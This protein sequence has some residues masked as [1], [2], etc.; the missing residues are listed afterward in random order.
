MKKQNR[1]QKT[2]KQE[3]VELM[4]YVELLE[5]KNKTL[6]EQLSHETMQ[7]QQLE[8]MYE[9]LL[10]EKN[11][12]IL[13]LKGKI[14]S[15]D[16]TLNS[17]KDKNGH[18][19]IVKGEEDDIYPGEQRDFILSLIETAQQSDEQYARRNHICQSLLK[20]NKKNG[21]REYMQDKIYLALK[22]FKFMDERTI[23]LL[24][25]SNIRL[26]SGRTHHKMTLNGDPRYR[27]SISKTPSDCR[28]GLNA[29]SEINRHFF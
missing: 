23:R 26:I 2:T 8:Q 27:V 24:E 6:V 19:L 9:E 3:K 20:A 12:E 22:D 7:Y 28:T 11:K 17:Y 10:E 14:I 5:E 21:T 15:Q 25:E 4:E 16:I 18:P 1:K 13:N 29:I